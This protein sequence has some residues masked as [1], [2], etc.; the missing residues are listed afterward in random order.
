L[1]AIILCTIAIVTPNNRKK[2]HLCT[3]DTTRAI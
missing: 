1:L 3:T 2:Y